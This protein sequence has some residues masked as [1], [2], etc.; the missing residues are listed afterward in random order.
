MTKTIK[1]FLVDDHSLVRAGLKALF[2]SFPEIE[3]VGEASTGE[4]LIKRYMN[5]RPDVVVMD[6]NMPGIGGLKSIQYLIAK[7]SKARI[8][9]LSAYDDTVHL[10]H[11]ISRGAT[12][13]ITKISVA[14]KVLEA[15][16]SVSEYKIYIDPSLANRIAIDDINGIQNPIDILSQREFEV[17]KAIANGM[18]VNQIAEAFFISPITAGCHFTKLKKKLNVNNSS[19]LVAVAVRFGLIN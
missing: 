7:D 9:I 3:V 1:V 14:E 18:S 6:I 16:K 2:D 10:K 19:E 11:A 13:Y 8:L 5:L 15:I 4:E 17:F 12:G